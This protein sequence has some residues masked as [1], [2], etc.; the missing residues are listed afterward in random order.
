MVPTLTS[1]MENKIWNP[2][3]DTGYGKKVVEVRVIHQ[4]KQLNRQILTPLLSLLINR[5]VTW[6]KNNVKKD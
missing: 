3:K 6:R 1:G 4:A 5:E 2:V